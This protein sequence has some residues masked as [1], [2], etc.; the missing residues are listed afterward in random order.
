MY[1]LTSN[2]G[3]LLSY[4]ITNNNGHRKQK[5]NSSDM[6]FGSQTFIIKAE[7]SINGGEKS[8]PEKFCNREVL[9][10]IRA[11]ANKERLHNKN[12]NVKTVASLY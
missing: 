11:S 12:N 7:Q 10:T 9:R 4:N 8:R 1:V 5:E 2:I 6:I 3:H